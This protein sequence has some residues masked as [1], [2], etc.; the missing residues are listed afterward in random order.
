MKWKL[1]N[2][3]A[4]AKENPDT[5]QIPD[6]RDRQGL[7]P[8][9]FA[10]LIFLHGDSG[11]RMWVEVK[12][13]F[14]PGRYE[15]VLANNPV[16]IESLEFGDVLKFEAKNVAEITDPSQAYGYRNLTM[17]GVELGGMFDAF[18]IW[19]PSTPP[20]EIVI[21]ESSPWFYSAPEEVKKRS[22]GRSSS[23]RPPEDGLPPRPGGGPEGPKD[24]SPRSSRFGAR[25]PSRY[26]VPRREEPGYEGSSEY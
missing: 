11:E 13:R 19:R 1:E 17:N 25:P 4:R 6:L 7:E 16:V 9:M 21:D 8:G 14:G 10:K 3:E 15:G 5:F 20:A 2:V 12:Q 26:D 24:W 18:E 22:R 23:I